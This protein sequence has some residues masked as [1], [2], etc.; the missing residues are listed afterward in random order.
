LGGLGYALDEQTGATRWVAR[1]FNTLD[2]TGPVVGPSL[3]YFGGTCEW[4]Y[5]ARP[6]D[7]S[8]AWWF[9]LPCSAGGRADISL[10]GSRLYGDGART[11]DAATGQQ[12]T[13]FA[14]SSRRAVASSA[15]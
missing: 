2:T 14:A 3:V 12:T 9:G 1:A 4:T 11:L 10:A 7:G 15:G 5:A 13:T 8:I 6:T